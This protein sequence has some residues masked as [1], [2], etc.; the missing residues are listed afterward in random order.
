MRYIFI[1]LFLLLFPNIS[2]AAEKC[3]DFRFSDSYVT[4]AAADTYALVADT[5][6]TVRNSEIFGWITGPEDCVDRNNA[7]NPKLAGIC[8][9]S[10]DG[11]QNEFRWNL[12][13]GTYSIRVALGDD[14]SAQVP[15]YLQILDNATSRVIINDTDGTVTAHWTDATGVDRTSAAD[16]VTN[17]AQVTGISISSGQLRFKLGTPT[18]SGGDAS[19]ISTICVESTGGGPPPSAA[20]GVVFNRGFNEGF[21]SGYN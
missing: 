5:Y 10:N 20:K 11:V 21:N 18:S 1:L 2:D 19:T 15:Q 12:T 13:A 8:Y 6:P 14:F 9:N 4:D 7:N 16:W 17:N 3:I